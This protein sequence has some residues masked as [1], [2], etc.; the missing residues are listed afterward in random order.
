MLLGCQLLTGPTWQSGICAECSAW[1]PVSALGTQAP[2]VY[3][4]ERQ[5]ETG[6]PGLPL[7]HENT[8][9]TT[10]LKGRTGQDPVQL[11]ESVECRRG[12]PGI[13]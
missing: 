12:E 4:L 8:S 6:G 11:G 3:S 13:T 10:D 2:L 5:R 9:Y 7:G 1:F